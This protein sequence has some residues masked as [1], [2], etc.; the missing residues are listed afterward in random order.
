MKHATMDVEVVV[1]FDSLAARVTEEGDESW[2][3]E[4][5]ARANDRIAMRSGHHAEKDF[6]R[7]SADRFRALAKWLKECAP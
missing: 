2:L 5:L 6:A 4:A 1:D 7:E 3:I